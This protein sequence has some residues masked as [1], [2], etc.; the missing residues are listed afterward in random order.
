[1]TLKRLRATRP[2]SVA[3]T[4]QATDLQLAGSQHLLDR[5]GRVS[6][7]NSRFKGLMGGK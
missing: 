1:M 7:F 6:R 4:G 2:T 5:G 3:K